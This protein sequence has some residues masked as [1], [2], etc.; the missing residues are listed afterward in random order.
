MFH[1]AF[2]AVGGADLLTIAQARYLQGLGHRP[3]VV[4][5]EIQGA[6]WEERMGTLPRHLVA[7][8]SPMDLLRG[9][10]DLGKVMARGH[11]AEAVLRD[12]ATVLAHNHPA[13][14]MLGHMDLPGE[15]LWYCHEPR[16]SLYPAESCPNLAAVAGS[17][18][19]WAAREFRVEPKHGGLVDHDRAAVARLDRIAVNSRFTGEALYRVYGRSPDAVIPPQIRFGTSVPRSG[20]LRPGGLQVLVQSRL[21]G[22]KNIDAVI[23]GFATHL[24]R[25]PGARLHVVGDGAARPRLEAL[26]QERAEGRVVFHGF[27]PSP[28]LEEVAAACDVFTLLPFDEPFGM[29]FPESAAR[30]LL[31]IGPD[32][33]GPLEILEGGELGWCVD[34]LDPEAL[35]GA[36]AQVASLDAAAVDA[37][38]SRADAACRAR[39]AE[40]VVGGQLLAFLRG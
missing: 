6:T 19:C 36:F 23:R 40:P 2:K 38:R 26:A 21:E 12:F 35:A 20:G 7:K 9:W 3:E 14:A 28:Q 31:L 25:D 30:G 8:R 37:R 24:R 29:V 27:L 15:R 22:I 10:S 39:Y 33:G 5:F 34:P 32:Q 16:R 17:E 1:P 18:R 13:S 11:R 4:T